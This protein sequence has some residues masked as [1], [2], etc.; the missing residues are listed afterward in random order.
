[1]SAQPNPAA[2]PRPA[3]AITTVE[4]P[5][6]GHVYAPRNVTWLLRHAS[7][8]HDIQIW[9]EAPGNGAAM[10]AVGDGKHEDDGWAFWMHWPD[11][12][13]LKAWLKRPTLDGVHVIWTPNAGKAK[14]LAIDFHGRGYITRDGEVFGPRGTIVRPSR[15]IG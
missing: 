13:I 10:L 15:R 12:S 3:T 1:M 14:T 8:V 4:Y 6:T 11:R 5:G 2:Q 9:D 7:Q